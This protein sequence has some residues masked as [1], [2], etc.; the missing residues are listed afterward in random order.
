MSTYSPL[1][2]LSEFQRPARRAFYGIKDV[3]R[4]IS[5]NNALQEFGF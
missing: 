2:S 4:N 3:I 1:N 5:E